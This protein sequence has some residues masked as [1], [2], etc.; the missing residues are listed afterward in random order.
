MKIEAIDWA[1]CTER[2]A[3]E[4][5]RGS[6]NDQEDRLKALE[7]EAK[8]CI[9]ALGKY[10]ESPTPTPPLGSDSDL[11]KTVI[12]ADMNG[13]HYE[14]QA[15]KQADKPEA[16]EE[17]TTGTPPKVDPMSRADDVQTAL[18]I[19]RMETGTY[20]QPE[21]PELKPC[22]FCGSEEITNHGFCV[23]CNHCTGRIGAATEAEAITAWQARPIEDELRAENKRLKDDIQTMINKTADNKL[24]GYRELGQRAADA[25]NERDELKAEIERLKGGWEASV[26]ANQELK[27]IEDKL[28]AENEE[29]KAFGTRKTKEVAEKDKEIE[30]LTESC[31]R[32]NNSCNAQEKDID[33]YKEAIDGQCPDR[34]CPI[35]DAL[36]DK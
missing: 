11:D 18:L 6:N 29:L 10:Y 25:E 33:R 17:V 2:L 5:L 1:R 24:D 16:P 32:L 31:T 28:R 30:H 27:A 13:G 14:T 4:K 35:L 19:H 20:K 26:F 23:E 22:P 3:I 21:A 36:K 8:G 7:G 12:V 34:I 9:K 15:E